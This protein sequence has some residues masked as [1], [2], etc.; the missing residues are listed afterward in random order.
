MAR[1]VSA[2]VWLRI[3]KAKTKAKARKCSQITKGTER[4]KEEHTLAGKKVLSVC[5]NAHFS[6]FDLAGTARSP[7]PPRSSIPAPSFPT[8]ALP[9]PALPRSLSISLF[10]CPTFCQDC[11]AAL[12]A[13]TEVPRLK[14]A[15]ASGVGTLGGG[16]GAVGQVH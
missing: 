9:C 1:G 8:P 5:C 6:S 3:Q 14:M 13:E 12:E 16:R 10:Q 15:T 4:A 11:C 2:I 7:P